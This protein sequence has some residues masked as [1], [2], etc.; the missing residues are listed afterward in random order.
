MAWTEAMTAEM[1]QTSGVREW[2]DSTMKDTRDMRDPQDLG[3]KL[4]RFRDSEEMRGKYSL[5]QV[6]DYFW[7]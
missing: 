4:R 5:S 6:Y 2:R 3:E 1:F 7:G